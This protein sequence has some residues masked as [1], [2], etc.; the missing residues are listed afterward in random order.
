MDSPKVF[1]C[2]GVDQPLD[3]VAY[4]IRLYHHGNPLKRREVDSTK[5]SSFPTNKDKNKNN[6]PSRT[7]YKSPMPSLDPDSDSDS[8]YFS[9]PITKKLEKSA[10][11]AALSDRT[12]K[13]SSNVAA[14]KQ[15]ETATVP[16][17]ATLDSRSS[18]RRRR[19]PLRGESPSNQ[20][21]NCRPDMIGKTSGVMFPTDGI[22]S[23]RRLSAKGIPRSLHM[24]RSNAGGVGHALIDEIT[25]TSFNMKAVDDSLLKFSML[26]K[27]NLTKTFEKPASRLPLPSKASSSS[28]DKSP[29]RIRPSSPTQ[30]MSSA[31]SV[32][33]FVHD[34]KKGKKC[35]NQSEDAH[36]LRLLYNTYLQWRF[37]NAQGDA[38]LHVERILWQRLEALYN[39]WKGTLEL[40]DSIIIKRINL[41]KLQLQLKLNV[42]LNEQVS[43][44]SQTITTKLAGNNVLIELKNA[45][46][47]YLEDWTLLERDHYIL[48]AGAIKNLESSTVRLHVTG[49]AT[50][51]SVSLNAAVG[52]AVAVMQGMTSSVSSVLSNVEAKG[53]LVSEL[54]ELAAQE[55]AMLDDCQTILASTA[56]VQ[57]RTR[58]QLKGPIDSTPAKLQVD[59]RTIWCILIQSPAPS[60]S[61]VVNRSSLI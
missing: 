35:V 11:H 56:A 36:R 40:W 15:P 6:G 46:L 49:G 57:V 7:S 33:D 50:A 31:T 44:L 23:L 5:K 2:S 34:L 12:V 30:K 55:M 39:V 9:V 14:H 19:S 60:T 20:S 53:C 8:D 27:Q 21:E 58:I 47:A 17:K 29:S 28:K 37:A 32:L 61:A 4:V 26:H 54:A 24:N 10:G 16:L 18:R 22:S 45:Q 51:D 43:L 25:K 1:G 59:H 38:A 3:L 13:P 41:Q 42:I 52:S 48:L